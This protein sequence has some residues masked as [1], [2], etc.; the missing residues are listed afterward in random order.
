M[1]VPAGPAGNQSPWPTDWKRLY[2]DPTTCAPRKRGLKNICALYSPLLRAQGR[3]ALRQPAPPWL[4]H[5]EHLCCPHN[6]SC[7]R[8]VSAT[9]HQCLSPLR[10][11]RPRA[12]P[13]LQP[14]GPHRSLW[15]IP[16]SFR[17]GVRKT[18]I[19]SG[20]LVSNIG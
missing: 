17:L 13:G 20:I 1:G 12:A 16:P 2:D 15:G 5:T 14:C 4:R 7:A 3:A 10:P 6:R 19:V 11:D 8:K 18:T 9:T